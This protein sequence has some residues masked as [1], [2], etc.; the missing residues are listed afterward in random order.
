MQCRRHMTWEGWRPRRPHVL[1]IAAL[2]AFAGSANAAGTGT[3]DNASGWY[4]AGSNITVT[5]TP[6]IYCQFD[7]WAGDTN[8]AVIAGTQISF[9]VTAPGNITAV[10]K[11][12]LTDTNSVP[13]WWLADQG[14][15]TNFE[16]AVT[17]DADGDSFTTAQEYWSGTDPTN[18]DSYLHINGID[19]TS[20]NL[21]LTWAHARV[22]AGIPAISIQRRANL[23]TGDWVSVVSTNAVDGT[24][25]WTFPPEWTGFFRL[26]V[27]NI[28]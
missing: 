7:R 10:F 15:T 2:L 21:M 19:M 11:D 16:T 22:D 3:L 18:A 14:I 13:Y 9:D 28:P 24:N 8:G 17:N 6:H 26:C 20:T 23:L 12:R 4:L 27:T 25:T 1:C 5:A